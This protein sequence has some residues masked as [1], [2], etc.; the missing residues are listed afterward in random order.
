MAGL[1]PLKLLARPA[2]F[3]PATY[4]FVDISKYRPVKDFSYLHIP[5]PIAIPLHFQG[6][7]LTDNI[8]LL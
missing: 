4:G 2:G 8:M 7:R 6:L 1:T 3:E 5:G